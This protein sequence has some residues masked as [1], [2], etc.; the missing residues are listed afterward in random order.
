MNIGLASLFGGEIKET[1]EQRLRRVI[2]QSQSRLKQIEKTKKTYHGKPCKNCGKTERRIT[3][4]KCLYCNRKNKTVADDGK[5]LGHVQTLVLRAL[6]EA[7]EATARQLE[8][9][10]GLGIKSVREALISLRKRGVAKAVRIENLGQATCLVFSTGSGKEV[11]FSDRNGKQPKLKLNAEYV[12]RTK[13]RIGADRYLMICR[14][15]RKGAN[16]VI[17]DGV[18]IWERGKGILV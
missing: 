2:A 14:A 15:R 5:P 17:C 6:E 9:V 12:A 13:E 18:K 3:N 10:T 1:E 16:V 8:D 11:Q 7:G 4:G